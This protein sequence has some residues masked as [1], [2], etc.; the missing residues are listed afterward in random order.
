M[1]NNIPRPIR[2]DDQNVSKLSSED[3]FSLNMNLNVVD[4]TPIAQLST[5]TLL[6]EIKV[7]DFLIFIE[8]KIKFNLFDNIHC[9]KEKQKKYYLQQILKKN[10]QYLCLNLE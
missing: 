10:F 6:S 1:E 2:S 9:R 8:N 4:Y 5:N 3:K 7:C